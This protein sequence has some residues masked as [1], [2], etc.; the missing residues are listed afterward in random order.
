MNSVLSYFSKTTLFGVVQEYFDLLCSSFGDHLITFGNFSRICLHPPVPCCSFW[1]INFWVSQIIFVSPVSS[2]C[3]WCGHY[4]EMIL[5]WVWMYMYCVTLKTMW[6]VIL[7]IVRLL[8][9][10]FHNK[11]VKVHAQFLGANRLFSANQ[12]LW[13]YNGDCPRFLTSFYCL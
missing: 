3:S 10:R 6:S 5:S 12:L 13:I 2:S 7:F 4:Y 8:I 1:N 11:P 9:I